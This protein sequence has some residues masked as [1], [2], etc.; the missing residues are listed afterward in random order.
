LKSSNTILP[1]RLL[2]LDDELTATL[3]ELL[4]TE[5]EELIKEMLDDTALETEEATLLVSLLLDTAALLCTLDVELPP[6]PPPPQPLSTSNN[7][8]KPFL[9]LNK[10]GEIRPEKAALTILLTS[11]SLC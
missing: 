11:Y 10:P 4:I 5:L 1:I 7:K 3:E 6:L 9:T 8:I 2:T